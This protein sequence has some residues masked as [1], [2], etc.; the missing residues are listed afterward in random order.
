MEKDLKNDAGTGPAEDDKER[1]DGVWQEMDGDPSEPDEAG[2]EKQDGEAGG[3]P[4][5]AEAD[6]ADG[7]KPAEDAPDENGKKEK[8]GFFSKKKDPRDTQIEELT[9]RLKR[10][11]AEFDNFRKRT[12]KEK[13][14]MYEVGA[15]SVIEKIL[16]VVDNFERGL[17]TIPEEAKGTPFADGVEKIYKQLMKT[18]DDLGVKPIEAV[19]QQ[20]DP[21]FHNAVMHVDDENLG[22]NVVAA[23]LQKGYMYR[24]SVVRHSMVQVA[25]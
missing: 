3:C 8:K 1:S 24:D 16:P 22:E 23:E 4:E 19:G 5:E 17:S 6:P 11:M 21:N 2:E 14:A 7:E 15:R 13:S 9:D 18:L 20:F 10:T 25:N 12:D